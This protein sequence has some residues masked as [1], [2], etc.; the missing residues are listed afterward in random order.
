MTTSPQ[1]ASVSRGDF[2]HAGQAR[3]R[4]ADEAGDQDQLADGQADHARGADIAAR[5]AGREAEHGVVDQ[6]IGEDA[7]DDPQHQAPMHFGAGDGADHVDV[8][9]RRRR[10]LVP[11]LFLG[12]RNQSASQFPTRPRL[13]P[14]RSDG[15][16]RVGPARSASPRLRNCPAWAPGRGATGS[17]IRAHLGEVQSQSNQ[18][19]EI[20]PGVKPRPGEFPVVGDLVR[21]PDNRGEQP[22]SRRAV[23]ERARAS[24]PKTKAPLLRAT[25]RRYGSMS[26]R[27]VHT[28]PGPLYDRSNLPRPWAAR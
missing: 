14:F 27:P 28:A 17:P 21:V 13:S 11:R 10:R 12:S 4:A 22:G 2:D 5:D 3:R 16:T 20:Q 8:A 15:S 1:A 26:G 18:L 9:D 23:G 19:T 7:S 6:D 25:G 24:P